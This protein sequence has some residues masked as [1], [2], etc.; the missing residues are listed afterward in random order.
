MHRQLG[1]EDG[2]SCLSS[3]LSVS[4][5]R[6]RIEDGA[7]C[8]S[9]MGVGVIGVPISLTSRQERRSACGTCVVHTLYPVQLHS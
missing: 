4:D 2:R 7:V 6:D 8:G 9:G 1:S 3:C 5:G